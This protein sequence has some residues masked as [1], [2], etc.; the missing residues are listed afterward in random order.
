MFIF[1]IIAVVVVFSVYRYGKSANKRVSNPID[2]IV[3]NSCMGFKLGDSKAF[4]LSRIEHMGL[5]NSEEKEDYD[6]NNETKLYDLL[7]DSPISTSSGKFNN[8]DTVSFCITSDILTS[9]HISL[10]ADHCDAHT[11]ISIIEKRFTNKFGSPEF[12]K[13]WRKGNSII[14]LDKDGMYVNIS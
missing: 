7:T 11:M 12:D 6:F 14:V 9:I 2:T 4:V 5:M 8:I 13:T 3:F 10:K 1:I